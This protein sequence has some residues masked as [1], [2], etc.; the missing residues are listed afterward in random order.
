MVAKSA[1]NSIRFTSASHDFMK[2]TQRDG[3]RL[4]VFCFRKREAAAPSWALKLAL[5]HEPR[6]PS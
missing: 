4:P 5:A 6:L 3:C 1:R 2:P